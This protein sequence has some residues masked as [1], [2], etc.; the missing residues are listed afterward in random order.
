VKNPVSKFAFLKY[1]LQRYVEEVLQAW[2]PAT[3]ARRAEAAGITQNALL[4]GALHV[5]SS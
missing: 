1:D 3:I 2:P 4:G 5:E